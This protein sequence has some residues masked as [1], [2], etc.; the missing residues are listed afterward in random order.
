MEKKICSIT[1]EEFIGY[2]NNAYPF[3]GICSDIANDL[4]VIPAR[5][6]HI[7]PDDIKKYGKKTIMNYIDSIR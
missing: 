5:L 1:G 2:G 7:T 6:M 3:V 4:Y